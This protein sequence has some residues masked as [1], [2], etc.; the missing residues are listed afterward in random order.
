MSAEF[1]LIYLLVV[2]VAA[3]SAFVGFRLGY[4]RPKKTNRGGDSA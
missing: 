3:V 1:I 4:S 2:A